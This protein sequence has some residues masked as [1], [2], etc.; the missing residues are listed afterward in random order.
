MKRGGESRRTSIVINL[1]H[2]RSND[3]KFQATTFSSLLLSPRRVSL[4]KKQLQTPNDLGTGIIVSRVEHDVQ[5]D[6]LL[7]RVKIHEIQIYLLA[8][9]SFV[10]A[11]FGS[12]N[13]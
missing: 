4:P 13:L 1:D 10:V 3:D 7:N 2:S 5:R 9:G 12:A 11:P 8:G 6:V